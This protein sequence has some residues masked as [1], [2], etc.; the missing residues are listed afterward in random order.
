MFKKLLVAWALLPLSVQAQGVLPEVGL[1]LHFVDYL[2]TRELARHCDQFRENNPI[3][4]K[5][6]KMGKVNS[7]FLLSGAGLYL[8]SKKINNPWI[9][10]GWVAVEALS[11]GNNFSIGLKG[12]F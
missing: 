4:G 11:V 9:A 12:G 5:C 2:Q 1:A 6:P 8:A 3:L 7:Y 10:R